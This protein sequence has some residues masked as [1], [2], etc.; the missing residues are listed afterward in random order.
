MVCPTP[1]LR[2]W[3]EEIARH[4]DCG[5]V[6]VLSYE[7]QGAIGKGQTRVVAPEELAGADIVLTTYDVLR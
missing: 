2:Q 1:L 7:G 4:V 6:K 5:A 3:A